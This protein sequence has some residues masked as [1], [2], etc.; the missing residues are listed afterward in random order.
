LHGPVGSPLDGKRKNGLYPFPV[1]DKWRVDTEGHFA[2][3]QKEVFK[4][5]VVD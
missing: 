5:G 2:N 4:D 1:E 3:K